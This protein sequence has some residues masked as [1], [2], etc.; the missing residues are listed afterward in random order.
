M[1]PHETKRQFL[2]RP[3]FPASWEI[4]STL[5]GS[6]RGGGHPPGRGL[7]PAAY[8]YFDL[9]CP[10]SYLAAERI[11]RLFARVIWRPVLGAAAHQG[12]PW[13][14]PLRAAAARAA[15]ERRAVELRVPLVWPESAGA[16]AS[17][18]AM[19]VASY[20]AECGRAAAFAL[21]A[22]RLAWGGGF[23]LDDPEVLAD[24]AAAASLGLDAALG[25]SGDIARD[26]PMEAAALRLLGA[27]ANKLPA[28]VAD[29]RLF[30]GELRLAE[31]AAALRAVPRGAERG[32]PA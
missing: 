2:F 11:E 31:A 10:F 26:G 19:R 21:A 12:D 3:P 7:W 16:D 4:S 9:A 18:A 15:A 14:D 6:G 29:R 30:A 17:T 13:T 23:E 22:G 25:A 28:V 20:A 27:G 24:A 32:I 5:S 8:F 1:M